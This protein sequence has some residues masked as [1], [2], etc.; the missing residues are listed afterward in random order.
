M[1]PLTP[2]LLAESAGIYAAFWAG[3]FLLGRAMHRGSDGGPEKRPWQEDALH[4]L[5][6][7]WVFASAAILRRLAPGTGFAEALGIMAAGALLLG[8]PHFVYR[9]KRKG[10]ALDG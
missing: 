6:F 1:T 5:W 4:A 8:L 3:M 7:A 10:E 2:R 9:R